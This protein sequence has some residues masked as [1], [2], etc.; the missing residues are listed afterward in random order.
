MFKN[1]LKITFR[2]I[3]G[4]KG[5]SFINITGLAIGMACFIL[6]LLLVLDELSYNRSHENAQRIYRVIVQSPK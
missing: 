3:K 4:S 5:Y 2:N 1:Y 6:M